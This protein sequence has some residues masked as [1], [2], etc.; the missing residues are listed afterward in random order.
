MK[1]TSKHFTMKIPT[2]KTLVK[3]LEKRC[4]E[5]WAEVVKKRDHWKCR[6][7]NR[8]KSDG[9]VLN[10]HHIEKRGNKSTRWETPNGI[11]L[12]TGHHSFWAHDP[13][14]N[15]Q[16]QHWLVG[17][18]GQKHLDYLRK[19]ASRIQFVTYEWL[20]DVEQQLNKENA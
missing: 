11:T 12:C 1:P 5:L 13:R 6:Y 9:V 7:C 15:S 16:Y 20:Q 10:A 17:E 18:V 4:D 19:E 8:G 2:R 3:K 14:G